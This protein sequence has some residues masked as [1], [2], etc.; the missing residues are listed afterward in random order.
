MVFSA[1]LEH[2][3]I[4]GHVPVSNRLSQGP[5]KQHHAFFIPYLKQIGLF[6]AIA[7]LGYLVLDLNQNRAIQ[8][9][10]LIVAARHN[11]VEFGERNGGFNLIEH[12]FRALVLV[13]T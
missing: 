1:L 2:E 9:D 7:L 8:A 13:V 3:D 10:V 4:I 12:F 11:P 5:F 6:H